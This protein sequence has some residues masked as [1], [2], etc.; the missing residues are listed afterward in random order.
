[1][2]ALRQGEEKLISKSLHVKDE[3]LRDDLLRQVTGSGHPA[4]SRQEP[5][6]L[7]EL[8]QLALDRDSIREYVTFQTKIGVAIGYL[9]GSLFAAG[10]AL[11][12]IS[13]VAGTPGSYGTSPESGI[14]FPVVCCV[15][16]MLAISS[17]NKLNRMLKVPEF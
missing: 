13:S 11:G 4:N 5:S 17:T 16:G 3:E 15:L 12:I 10:G 9:V 2:G 14:W 6:I 7:A 1:M 8:E